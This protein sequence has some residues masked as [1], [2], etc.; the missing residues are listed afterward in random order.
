MPTRTPRI[1]DAALAKIPGK[2]LY[3]MA[4]A[5]AEVVIGGDHPTLALPEARA[6]KWGGKCWLRVRHADAEEIDRANKAAQAQGKA[7]KAAE[8]ASLRAEKGKPVLDIPT[9]GKGRRHEIREGSLKWDVVYDSPAA[10]PADGIERF[11]LEFPEGLTWHYQPALTAEEIAEGHERPEEMVGGYVAYWAQCG[12]YLDESGEEVANYETGRFGDIKAPLWVDAA[13]KTLRWTQELVG[14]ELRCY[15]PTEWLATAV[16]PVR[17]D[18][19]FGFNSFGASSFAVYST[20]AYAF[21]VPQPEFSGTVSKITIGATYLGS[22]YGSKGKAAVYAKGATVAA[23]T[24]LG[25]TP[26]WTAAVTGGGSQAWHDLPYTSGPE[27]SASTDYLLG[28]FLTDATPTVTGYLKY[29]S[30]SNSNYYA[31]ADYN[32]DP[33]FPGPYGSGSAATSGYMSIYATYEESGGGSYTETLDTLITSISSAADQQAYRDTVDTL[34]T[35]GATVEAVTGMVEALLTLGQ[36]SSAATDVQGYADGVSD[37]IVS[38]SSVTD[39]VGTPPITESLLTTAVSASNVSAAQAYVE[40][41]T[42]LA[43]SASN[44]GEVLGLVEQIGTVGESVSTVSDR[45]LYYDNVAIVA[46]SSS[47]LAEV[48]AYI[49]QVSV[50][51]ASVS[52]VGEVQFDPSEVQR[53]FSFPRRFKVFVIPT[54]NKTFRV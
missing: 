34:I 11:Q 47:S 37:T 6:S 33:N 30:A 25:Q 39:T 36:S 27:I 20:R 48:G 38:A 40:T 5:G 41:V 35:S 18:P 16:Y 19:E 4:T 43:V 24:L 42:A 49:E 32:T 29:D 54:R 14:S 52:S 53:L 28:L 10:L 1:P 15:L 8:K 22:N 46:L 7:L 23:S 21:S 3:R 9:T 50:A 44:L 2:A 51:A 17:L 13:G 26:E 12:R 45:Q 31:I